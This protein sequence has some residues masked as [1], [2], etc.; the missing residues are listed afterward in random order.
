MSGASG[1][2]RV[3]CAGASER[4][5]ADLERVAGKPLRAPIPADPGAGDIVFLDVSNSEG[6]PFGNAF[7]ACRSLKQRPGVRVYLL[8][9]EG[10]A[11][12]AEIGRFCLADACFEVA[13]GGGLSDAEGV[14]ARLAPHRPKVEGAGLLAELERRLRS[15]EGRAASVIQKLLAADRQEWI[16]DHLT[17]PETGLFAGPFASFKLDEEFKRA[18]R[19]HQPLS[20]LLLD[21]GAVDAGQQADERRRSVLAEVASVLLNECRDIDVLARFTEST[22]LLLLPG[23]GVDGACHLG[24]RLL[25]QLGER[26]IAAGDPSVGI[27]TVPAADMD[28]RQAFL[29]RAEA[30]LRVAQERAGEGRLYAAQPAAAAPGG[31]RS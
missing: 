7:S 19:F 10:D 30:C 18:R 3:F 6:V 29:A 11:F 21:I 24:R 26:R 1:S 20:L 15:G 2:P 4:L 25:A 13:P 17:D 8:V 14:R 27:A 23:T 16:L 28:D 9:A 12:S 31:L 22:F 5:R